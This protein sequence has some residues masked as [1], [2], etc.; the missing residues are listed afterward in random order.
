MRSLHRW[1]APLAA[2]FLIIIAATGVYMQGETLW[3]AYHPARR[4]EAQSL[5][6]G[7]ISNWFD[8]ALTAARRARPESGIA[9]VSVSMD[10]S[11]PRADV[12][13]TQSDVPELSI[14]PRTGS[15]FQSSSTG[16]ADQSLSRRLGRLILEL[17]R[18]DLL[19][20]PGRWLGF[21]CG[22]ALVLLGVT[23]LIVYLKIYLRRVNLR[24]WS[25]FW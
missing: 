20:L 16:A 21:A 13:W 3:R 1:I 14:D 8:L 18:G 9:M 4:A 7:E 2:L 10:G 17:H 6:A 24:R 12:V 22:I 11:Q 25:P 19:G 15:Q 23:G 5:P